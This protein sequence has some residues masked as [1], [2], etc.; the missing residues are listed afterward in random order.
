MY[1]T[2][3]YFLLDSQVEEFTRIQF[4]LQPRRSMT[5]EATFV[6]DALLWRSR[7]AIGAC[8][9]VC[10]GSERESK[11]EKKEYPMLVPSPHKYLSEDHD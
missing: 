8:C 1:R 10:D 11:R 5:S 6:T 3:V 2:V 4:N 9:L 7:I